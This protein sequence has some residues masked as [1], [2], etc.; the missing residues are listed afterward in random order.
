[1]LHR[2][3]ER[4]MT[5]SEVLETTT[6]MATGISGLDD[7]L[8]GGLTA[9]RMYLVE[10]TPGTGKT[11]L[12]LQFLLEGVKRGERSIY[13]T[14]SETASEL[15]AVARSHGWTL[16]AISVFELLSG[17]ELEPDVEQSILHPSE[18]ELGET[19]NS[20]IK[21][22]QQQR[23]VR[24]AF[25][26]LS[27]LRLLAQNP[28]RYRRQILALKHFFNHCSC[29][30]VM[31]D[32]K[33]SSPG[34]LQLHSIAHGVITLEQ[35]PREFGTERRRLRVVKMRGIKYRS[36]YHDFVLDTGGLKIFPRLVAAEHGRPF[37][38]AAKSTGSLELDSLL[39]GGLVPGT[40]TLFNGPAGVGKTSTAIRCVLTALQRGER[41]AYYLFDEGLNT[42]LTRCAALDMDIRSYVESGQLKILQIDPAELS[43]GEFA[44]AV[45]RSVEREDARFVVI[46]SLNAYIQA[47]PGEQ[48]L[49]LQMHE[50]LSYLNQ[51]GVTTIMVLGQHGLIGEMRSE[52]DLSYLSDTIVLFRFFEAQG[53]I[54]TAVSVLKSRTNPH[55]RTIRE[56]TLGPTGLKVGDALDDFEGVM[57]GLPTYRGSLPMLQP[58]G[59]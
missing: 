31:L 51:L 42:L 53:Q 37:S 47:M 16:D 54:L 44:S 12:A 26:S 58:D 5:N 46:D 57:S 43:P 52:V 22:V 6:R 38:G 17:A 1:M 41:A 25:D 55:Q 35:L 8:G 40:N 59:A 9:Q 21:E 50:L 30:V 48:Y 4:I 13:V 39:G 18:I 56:F 19:V 49:M 2:S 20:I 15:R 23:P 14:L 11:T 24:V 32:D 3:N 45:R 33:T 10:G 36:G 29:T 34:D 7:I 28:L 27:E